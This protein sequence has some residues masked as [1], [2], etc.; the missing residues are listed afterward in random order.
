MSCKSHVLRHQWSSWMVS[1]GIML[2]I[3]CFATPVIIMDGV[4][5]N[6]APISGNF[7][8][9]IHLTSFLQLLSIYKWKLYNTNLIMFWWVLVKKLWTNKFHCHLSRMTKKA[10][11]LQFRCLDY[12]IGWL[13]ATDFPWWTTYIILHLIHRTCIENLRLNF[14]WVCNWYSNSIKDVIGQ[15]VQSCHLGPPNKV[16]GNAEIIL[17]QIQGGKQR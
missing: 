2:Q 15:S 16:M 3:A 8:W 5:W 14:R 7:E 12:N 6:N 11:V 13:F 9:E 1:R 4:M 17:C 10:I